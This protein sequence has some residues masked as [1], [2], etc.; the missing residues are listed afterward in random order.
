MLC[1]EGEISYILG[2]E[3]GGRAWKGAFAVPLDEVFILRFAAP[4]GVTGRLEWWNAFFRNQWT[5]Q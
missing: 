3:N 2:I 5:S 4:L 1:P